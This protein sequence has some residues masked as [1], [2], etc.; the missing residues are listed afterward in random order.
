MSIK[1]LQ[2]T[3]Q[4][5]RT[6]LPLAGIVRGKFAGLFSGL[7]LL[8]M[9]LIL[10]SGCVSNGNKADPA[11]ALYGTWVTDLGPLGHKGHSHSTFN[12]DGTYELDM[13]F[14]VA[15]SDSFLDVTTTGTFKAN[16]TTLSIT[17][18]SGTR[19]VSFSSEAAYNHAERR[20]TQEEID[21]YNTIDRFIWSIDGDVLT[22]TDGADIMRTYTRL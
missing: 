2:S 22:L 1:E 17:H 10:V 19:A 4:K 8:T 9:A 6:N 7:I 15:G 21:S 20:M 5:R 14:F 12:S 16:A 11:S 13:E 18:E 3:N